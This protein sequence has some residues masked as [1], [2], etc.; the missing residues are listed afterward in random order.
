MGMDQG[1]SFNLFVAGRAA[2][3]LEGDWL[4]AQL[5]EAKKADDYGVVPF[6]TGTKRLYGFAEYN[7]I[8]TEEQEPRCLPRSFSTS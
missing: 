8:S 1:Q 2:M 3:M 6:P 4:A 7:Y 5:K